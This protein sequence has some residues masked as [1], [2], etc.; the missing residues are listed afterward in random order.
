MKGVGFTLLKIALFAVLAWFVFKQI[1]F[2]DQIVTVVEDG[3]TPPPPVSG[4]LDGDWQSADWVFESEDGRRIGPADLQPD[5]ELR[6]GFVALLTNLRIPVFLVAIVFWAILLSIVTW[7]W[8]ILLRAVGVE[9]GY[10]NALRL[11][12]IGYFFNNV[13]PGLTGGDLV[14]AVLV[15]R[16]LEANRAKAALSVLIDRLIGLFSLLLLAAGVLAFEVV[17][18]NP[19]EVKHLDT[20]AKGVFLIIVIAVVGG[21]VYL[22]QRMRR[23]LYVDAIIQKLPARDI[24]TKVDGAITAYRQAPKAIAAALGLSLVLQACGVM[25]FWATGKALGASM[26]ASDNFIMFPVVQT[27]SSVPLTPPA[28]WGVGETLYGKFYEWFG[29]T[30]TLGVAVSILFRLT[31]QVGFGLIGGLVWA[32]SRDKKGFKLADVQQS[33]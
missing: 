24:V 19:R 32:L 17:R 9:T 8:K 1:E 18:D 10:L 26:Q 23:L 22:S 3:S 2:R 7:R 4:Q 11:C 25:S 13:M 21:G 6:P 14:R 29:S 20:V 5:E 16:G 30:F 27:I 15:T 33:S 28:G 31:S 12:F